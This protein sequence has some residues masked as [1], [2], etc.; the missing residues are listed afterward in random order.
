MIRINLL[1]HREEKRRAKQRRFLSLLVFA[2]VGAIG[3]LILGFTVLAAKIDTQ[4]SRNDFLA[5]ENAKLDR[6]IAEIEKLKTEKQALLDRKKV[7]ERL[8]SNRTEAVRVVDQLVRQTPEGIYLKDFKQ[9]DDQITLVGY[10]QSNARVSTYMRNLNDSPVF[11]QPL[12]VEVKAANVGNLR[13]S[14][15]NLR[16]R[17]TRTTDA[18][19]SAS[20]PAGAKRGE[21]K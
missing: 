17:V 2:F 19:A 7:V 20:M 13:L 18:A 16:T 8:Q 11:E 5:A 21:A 12:L 15:F 10:A 1:P 4:R 9:A 6:E 14:E 3:V